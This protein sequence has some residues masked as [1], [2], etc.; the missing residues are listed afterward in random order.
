MDYNEKYFNQIITEK[1]YYY[2][3]YVVI[4]KLCFL[5][6]NIAIVVLKANKL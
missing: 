2:L 3:V 6:V 5:T 1:M 4:I